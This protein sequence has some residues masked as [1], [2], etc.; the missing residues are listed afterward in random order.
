[1]IRSVASDERYV[2][3]QGLRAI[4]YAGRKSAQRWRG[5]L[6]CHSYHGGYLDGFFATM[7]I[8]QLLLER[9]THVHTLRSE[10]INGDDCRVLEGQSEVGDFR[11]WI[12]PARQHRI[13][14]WRHVAGPDHG[15]PGGPKL[16]D[17]EPR[18]TPSGQVKVYTLEHQAEV[19]EF[20]VVDGA[21]VPTAGV[22]RD[23]YRAQDGTLIEESECRVHRREVR[24]LKDRAAVEKAFAVEI[25]DGTPVTN[26]DDPSGVQYVWQGGRVVRGHTQFSGAARGHW[27]PRSIWVY[28][29]WIVLGLITA[30]LALRLSLARRSRPQEEAP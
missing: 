28:V 17:W 29:G 15:P 9:G 25:P 5:I 10:R 3:A 14:R 11:V 1:V 19:A 6:V 13:V 4:A 21:L 16:R 24:F 27:Q 18:A 7:H 20:A 2:S 12:A 22:L 23:L 8:A 26:L 30:G